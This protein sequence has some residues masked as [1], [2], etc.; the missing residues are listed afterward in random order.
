MIAAP[1]G[2][3]T[4]EDGARKNVVEDPHQHILRGRDFSMTFFF[5]RR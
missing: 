4:V 2:G 5:I 3:T 1:D